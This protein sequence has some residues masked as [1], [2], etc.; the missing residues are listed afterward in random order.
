M[1]TGFTHSAGSELEKAISCYNAINP[2]PI[3]AV[4]E[5]YRF[6]PAFVEGRKLMA[7]IGDVINIHVIIEGSMNS[8]NPYYSSSWRRDFSGGFILYM[9]VHF[10]YG[11]RMLAGC[12]ITSVSA[13]TSHVDSTLPPPDHISSTIQ[14]EN[15]SFGVFVV[16]VSS[17]S[18]KVLW[19]IVGLKGTLQVERGSKDGKHGYT[20]IL[21]TAD[22]QSK[23][24]FYPF[25]G[26]TDELKTFLSDISLASLKN[27]GS[28]EV[29]P[30]LSFVKGARDVAVLDVMLESGKKQVK[31]QKSAEAGTIPSFYK[32][33]PEEGSISH[34]VQ[35]LAKY[36]FLKEQSDLLLNV[37]DLVV[38]WVC[39]RENCVIDDATSAEK[40]NYEDFCHIASNGYS[41]THSGKYSFQNACFRDVLE[42]IVFRT[43]VLETFWKSDYQE[44]PAEAFLIVRLARTAPYRT[45]Q[46]G[47]LN[48]QKQA[49]LKVVSALV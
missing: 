15:G 43:P 24:W 38:M 3:W 7:E 18:P 27:D 21:F 41:K 47:V 5:N 22:G 33:K 14:L 28:H 39:L 19:R 45:P 34:R 2:A 9:G 12:E 46:Q 30:R 44:R 25:S 32:K 11:L 20:V 40:M 36:R 6:E 31:Q 1:I 42:S 49:F 13:I 29:E 26:V 17:R 48:L 35:R 10:I 16:V 37:D 23:S 4:A 8:S